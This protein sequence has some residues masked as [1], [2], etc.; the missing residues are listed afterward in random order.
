MMDPMSSRI[1]NDR[2]LV[3]EIQSQFRKC[4]EG[5]AV[6]MFMLKL[7]GLYD[8]H[9]SSVLGCPFRERRSILLSGRPPLALLNKN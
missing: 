9:L 6:G 4:R 5:I 8:D 3:S 1:T 7:Q 2:L